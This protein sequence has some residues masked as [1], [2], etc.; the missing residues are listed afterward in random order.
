MDSLNLPM[1]L[2]QFA[3]WEYAEYDT[4][5]G[6]YSPGVT[7]SGILPVHLNGT[8]TITLPTPSRAGI[9]LII[10]LVKDT[11]GTLTITTQDGQVMCMNSATV[12]PFTG[13]GGTSTTVGYFLSLVS[14]PKY[15][16]G[17]RV[18]RWATTYAYEE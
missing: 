17:V 9:T 16:S 5:L 4:S 7:K 15:V 8:A 3:D 14:L 2:A 18:Y 13:T 6:D 12:A 11:T 1:H 10:V